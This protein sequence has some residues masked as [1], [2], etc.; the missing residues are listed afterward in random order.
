[1]IVVEWSFD[2]LVKT[3]S[4]VKEHYEGQWLTIYLK[5]KD[6]ILKGGFKELVN[7]DT[8]N[9]TILDFESVH[10]N[11]LLAKGTIYI[12]GSDNGTF[13]YW[14]VLEN[15]DGFSM[16]HTTSEISPYT[17]NILESN[18][19]STLLTTFRSDTNKNSDRFKVD[20]IVPLIL[21]LVIIH[22]LFFRVASEKLGLGDYFYLSTV[23]LKYI[24]MCQKNTSICNLDSLT[25]MVVFYVMIRSVLMME[26]A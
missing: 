4:F 17:R 22:S 12:G 19:Q 5:I 1:M 2:G 8:P 25:Q 3:E 23:L 20:K 21:K 16:T 24:V 10:F 14:K 6:S 13:N 11:E 18:T 26:F 9:F 7:D 15:S